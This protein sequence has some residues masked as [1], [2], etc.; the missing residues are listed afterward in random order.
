MIGFMNRQNECDIDPT[1][2]NSHTV[3]SK[4]C[5]GTSVEHS[6]IDSSHKKVF[7]DL[8]TF[9]QNK[10]NLEYSYVILCEAK[11]FFCLPQAF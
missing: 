8:Y 9:P 6:Y 2:S 4:K 1:T 11:L 3:N 5:N 7:E 10:I